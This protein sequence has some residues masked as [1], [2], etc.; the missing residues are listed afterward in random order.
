M[1][2]TSAVLLDIDGTLVDSTLHHALAWHR[3]FSRH[4]VPVALWRIHRAIGMGGDRL[5]EHVAGAAVEESKG[6]ELRAAWRREYLPL[7]A[8][9]RPLPGAEDLVVALRRGGFR[10]ALAS[11]GDPQFAREAVSLLGLDAEIEILTT[12]ADVDS[13]KPDPDLVG[14]TLRRMG[15]VER[16][17]FVGDTGYDVES[18]ARAGLPCIGLRT[19][20]RSRQ[21]LEEAGAVLVVGDPSDLVEAD[22]AAYL[23]PVPA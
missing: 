6:D 2:D 8:E 12:A 1:R 5:V 13:S 9:V 3:A 20:G 16:A 4:G 15:G 7:R 23:G 18:A 19:G 22:W 10:V 14:E 11:S 21:E 17:V